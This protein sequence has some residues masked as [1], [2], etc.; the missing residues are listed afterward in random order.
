MFESI[1]KDINESSVYNRV[2]KNFFVKD[3]KSAGEYKDACINYVDSD[4]DYQAYRK[5]ILEDEAFTSGDE[6]SQLYE[7][8]I[9][10]SEK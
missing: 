7:D 1:G 6:M 10:T 9:S 8:M 3:K 4:S 2:D 5:N